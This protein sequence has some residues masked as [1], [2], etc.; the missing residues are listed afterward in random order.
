[1]SAKYIFSFLKGL[2]I[3]SY[4]FMI[5]FFIYTLVK[6]II[7]IARKNTHHQKSQTTSVYSNE[8]MAFNLKSD[9]LP[10]T[11]SSDSLARYQRVKEKYMLQVNPNSTIGYYALF[12]ELLLMSLTIAI[13]RNF[14]QIFREASL[15]NPFRT[16]VTNRLKIIAA[17][18]IT[19]DILKLTHYFIFNSLLP[20]SFAAA[21]FEL[22]I[23]IGG[24]LI[25]GLVIWIIAIIYQRGIGLQQENALT[26]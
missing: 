18:F 8:V 11:Y 9:E 7:N 17:L 15:D 14:K 5:L 26:I 13:L 10:F 12:M 6:G 3:V 2:V 25:T 19:T 16:N 21:K 22:V 24:N 1:M 4:Y 23:T 20:E